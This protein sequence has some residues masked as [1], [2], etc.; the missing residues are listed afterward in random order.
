ME[1]RGPET[2]KEE[3]DTHC[4]NKI[5]EEIGVQSSCEAVIFK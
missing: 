1:R 3:L 5:P 2:E 4:G